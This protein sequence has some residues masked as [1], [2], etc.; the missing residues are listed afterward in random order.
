M[1]EVDTSVY[2]K[3]S[4]GPSMMDKAGSFIQLQQGANV[5]KLFRSQGAVGKAAQDA[6]GDDGQIDPTK[7]RQ[8]IADN[9]LAMQAAPEGIQASQA[10]DQA[11]FTLISQQQDFIRN[12]LGSLAVKPDLSQKDV[13][14][15]VG[16]MLLNKTLTPQQAAVELASAPSEP[17]QLRGWVNNHLANVLAASE[18]FNAAYGSPQFVPTVDPKTGKPGLLPVAVPSAPGMQPRVIGQQQTAA[19]GAPAQPA[20]ENG[21]IVT[22]PSAGQAELWKVSTDRYNS[23]RDA[24]A[25]YPQQSLV[26]NKALTNL[27]KADTG[28]GSGGL[29][30]LK[31]T[32]LTMARS[33]GM[34][35]VKGIDNNKVASFDEA[36]KYLTQDNLERGNLLGAGTDSR[37]DAVFAGSP[38]TDIDKA[39]AIQV[40]KTNLALRRTQQ[41]LFEEFKKTGQDPNTFQDWVAE[42]WSA[43]IDP[44]AFGA[45][46]LSKA[47]LKNLVS[48]MSP[49]EKQ[50]F[51]GSIALAID[52]KMLSKDKIG[53]GN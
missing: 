5:N 3:L 9:P 30:E 42:N 25:N 7:M 24:A 52:H 50:R 27:K 39:A 16:K 21:S 2:N 45:D 14:D 48:R 31:G 23:S 12:T 6:I 26:L 46:L 53:T 17:E 34:E 19:P 13:V 41:A 1:A 4:G 51:A 11:R 38:T 43:N 40:T 44:V 35:S 36:K 37:L 20:I 29:Q 32:I 10:M 8:N 47:E 28:Q 22:G 49:E 15:A 18:K 33:L